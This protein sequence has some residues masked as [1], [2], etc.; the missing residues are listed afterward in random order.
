MKSHK[1]TE[2][3]LIYILFLASLFAGFF[4]NEDFAGGA[5][6]DYE[7]HKIAASYFIDDFKFALLNYDKLG[8]LHSP[9]FIIFVSFLIE[10]SEN[11]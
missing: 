3:I 7:L 9:L 2:F 1:I 11:T 4:I 6:P 5:R 10:T 8:N